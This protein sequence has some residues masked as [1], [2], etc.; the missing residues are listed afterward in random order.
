MEERELKQKIEAL[1]GEWDMTGALEVQ[2]D[3]ASIAKLFRSATGETITEHTR[4]AVARH[5]PFLLGYCA[6]RMHD[7]G[8]I[9]LYA[10]L[11]QDKLGNFSQIDTKGATLLDALRNETEIFDHL[12]PFWD[13]M[14][15]PLECAIEQDRLCN[16]VSLYAALEQGTG[17]PRKRGSRIKRRCVWR[18]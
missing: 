2:K 9:D 13:D 12:A 3:G 14:Q 7:A 16:D 6:A 18:F 5:A 11:D 1:A 4:F 8:A 17:C 10:P 15:T